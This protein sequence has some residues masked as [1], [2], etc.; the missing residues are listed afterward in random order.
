MHYSWQEITAILEGQAINARTNDVLTQPAYDSRRIGNPAQTLFF[1]LPGSHRQGAEFVQAAAK[2]GVCSFIVPMDCDVSVLPEC[3]VLRVSDVLSALQ[4]LAA[5]HRSRFTGPVIGVTGSNGK[6]I[7]KEWLHQL[8]GEEFHACRSPRSFN[9]QIGVAISL[10]GIE[11]WHKMAII[12]AGISK[13]LEM[14]RLWQ[15]IKPNLAICTHL[16]SAHDEGFDSRN[17]K[18]HEKALLFKDA[19]VVVFPGDSP[20][21]KEAVNALKVKQPMTKF[22]SWGRTEGNAY[23]MLEEGYGQ[24]F[25]Q[26]NFLHRGTEH[27]LE[28]PFTDQA[29]VE[30]AM[31]CLCALA[32]LERWDASH[33]EQFR[34]L[35][36]LENRLA[37]TEGRNGNYLVNDS[38]SNDPDS[39][40]VALDFMV[41]Q[42]PDKPA[43]VILS[44][45]DQS[46]P[47][48]MRLSTQISG[49][50]LQKRVKRL[51]LVGTVLSDYAAQFKDLNPEFFPD[52]DALIRSG[53]LEQLLGKAILIKGSRRFGFEKIHALLKKQLHKTYLQIDLEALRHNYRY[54]RNAVSP[55][56]RMMAMVKAFGYGSG[57]FEVART[58]QFMGVDYLAV[59]FADEGVALRDAGIR[60]P[61]MVMNTGAED[62]A[63]RLQYG[64]EPVVFDLNGLEAMAAISGNTE[65]AVHLEVDTGMHRLGFTPDTLKDLPTVIPANIRIASVFTHLAASEDPAQDDFTQTQIEQFT[66]AANAF[67]RQL[68]YAPIRHALN[69]GGILRFAEYSMDMVRLGVGLYGVDPRN[70]AEADLK[71]VTTLY[72]SIS[73]LHTLQPGEGVG[74]GRRSVADTVRTIATLPVGYAD[75]LRRSLGNGKWHVLVNGQKA[76]IVGSVCMDMC[77]VDVTGIECHEGD[78]VIVFGA[79]NSVA[80]MA[81]CAYTIPYEILT[82]IS[83]RVPREYVGEN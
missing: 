46:D 14:E 72:S 66:E 11:P 33:L 13:P 63:S 38:Y 15:M 74:Y 82:G 62:M 25:T 75:G 54:F 27:Q 65:I 37:F 31:T 43:C 83:A 24:G 1:A 76:P 42:Q 78:N 17:Q 44:D 60:V 29:A 69:T 55:K 53:S 40:Q 5:H 73:Q 3:N 47:D 59:A 67:E 20:E 61:I 71:P 56:T 49:I 23:R 9:S 48:K 35:H 6:T 8:L 51:I 39:L 12:E 19:D 52:T 16:G 22:I 36:A 28:I 41:R 32:A 77:M 45:M 58:L 10:L 57:S 26:I 79:D 80:A 2:Q 64:L 34:H 70:V 30:N 21:M 4:Q 7:V 68:G 50:L 81:A 18:A